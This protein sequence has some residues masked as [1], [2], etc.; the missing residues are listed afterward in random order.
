[1]EIEIGTCPTGIL[2]ALKSVDGRIHQ[3]TAI[4]QASLIIFNVIFS[5]II[6]KESVTITRMIGIFIIIIGIIL[7]NYG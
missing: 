6:L 4:V 5:V 7:V 1:M 2:L 3:V